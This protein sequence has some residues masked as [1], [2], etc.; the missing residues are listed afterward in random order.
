MDASPPYSEPVCGDCADRAIP[1]FQCPRYVAKAG[2]LDLAYSEGRCP[3]EFPACGDS[4][5]EV[6]ALA[7]SEH[8]RRCIGEKP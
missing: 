6:N 5:Y 2:S 4:I 1:C 8:C 3:S 7:Q